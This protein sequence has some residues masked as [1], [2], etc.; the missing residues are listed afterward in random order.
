M[1]MKYIRE[2]YGVPAKRGA[3]LLYLGVMHRVCSAQ[4]HY[5]RTETFGGE[6][7]LIHPTWQA[8]WLPDKNGGER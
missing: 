8:E 6:R 4:G 7:Y 1:S 2:T 5:L 3:R